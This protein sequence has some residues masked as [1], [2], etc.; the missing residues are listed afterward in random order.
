MSQ[1]VGSILEKGVNWRSQRKEIDRLRKRRKRS[2]QGDE[3]KHIVLKK[4][5]LKNASKAVGE[6]LNESLLK[7]YFQSDLC[8]WNHLPREDVI[9]QIRNEIPSLAQL[10]IMVK[11]YNRVM[12][13]NSELSICGACG[14]LQIGPFK[15]LAIERLSVLRKLDSTPH[16]AENLVNGYHLHRTPSGE[17]ILTFCEKCSESI[18][19]NEIPAY[20][21][22]GG[23]DYGR[24]PDDLATLNDIEQL[25]ISWTIPFG[26]VLKLSQNG[27]LGIKG[28]VISFTNDGP[29]VFASRL[30]NILAVSCIS[31]MFQGTQKQFLM[32][33]HQI[34]HILEIRSAL[35]FRWLHFLKDVNP[36]YADVTID[37]SVDLQSLQEVIRNS[38]HVEDV[39]AAD[40]TACNSLDIEVN[41]LPRL[42]GVFL[43]S[44][45]DRSSISGDSLT[46]LKL[47]SMIL[48]T[49]RSDEPLCEFTQNSELFLSAF[50]YLF[51]LGR[52]LPSQGSI[53]TTLI[54]H[55]LRQ[56][57]GRFATDHRFL[58]LL[59]NQLQRHQAIRAVTSRLKVQDDH[60]LEVESIIN[61]TAFQTQLASI[62]NNIELQKNSWFLAKVHKLLRFVE[63]SSARV[64]YTNSEAKDN[65]SKLYG[66][67]IRYGL[68]SFWLT[69]SPAIHES[70]LALK[71]ILHRNG[72]GATTTDVT[73]GIQLLAKNPVVA[74]ETFHR[75]TD[76][77]LEHL[78][79]FQ[80]NLR[81][82][83]FEKSKGC[84]GSLTAY[85]LVF[86][87]QGRGALHHHGLYWGSV[88]PIIFQLFAH[89]SEIVQ[90]LSR[91][92]D[93]TLR[94]SFPQEY[95]EIHDKL[96]S[97][98][99]RVRPAQ[100]E[101]P[102]PSSTD[103]WY[104][105]YREAGPTMHIHT[106][107][108]TCHK[109]KYGQCRMAFPQ[110]I[111][112]TTRPI[113]LSGSKAHV[114]ASDSID[115][116]SIPSPS[117]YLNPFPRGD[118]RVI[119]WELA[120][121][122]MRDRDVVSHPPVL[123]CAL[124]CNVQASHL[125]AKEDAKSC[126]FYMTGYAC[127]GATKLAATV[128]PLNWARIR[129]AEHR[130]ESQDDIDNPA[131]LF[132]HAFL[133]KLNGAA[134][135]SAQQAASALLQHP[136]YQTSD[137]FSWC[138]ILPAVEQFKFNRISD[139]GDDEPFDDAD[140]DAFV[141][142]GDDIDPLFT[143]HRST[144][145][146]GPCS[147]L[148][149]EKSAS[150]RLLTISQ[151]EHYRLRGEALKHLCFYEWCALIS[152]V[153]RP[154]K[155]EAKSDKRSAGR[156]QNPQYLFSPVH[157]LHG[158]MCQKLRSKICTPR[159]AGPA[160][161]Q[162]PGSRPCGKIT[163]RGWIRKAESFARYMCVLLVPW[164]LDL[165]S[166]DE[167]Q[168][169][170]RQRDWLSLYH[171]RL[172]Q[173][174]SQASQP[175][176]SDVDFNRSLILQNI[177]EVKTISTKH[178]DMLTSWRNRE[179]ARWSAI[180]P[181]NADSSSTS[182]NHSDGS[183]SHD[184]E[185]RHEILQ[186]VAALSD[187]GVSD[188]IDR[189][190]IYLNNQTQA[191]RIFRP[192][193]SLSPTS[194]SSSST[195]Q[196]C[197]FYEDLEEINR[198]LELQSSLPSLLMSSRETKGNG[199]NL[200][201]LD[202]RLGKLNAQQ[203]SILDE[204]KSSSWQVLA[205]ILGGPGTGKSFLSLCISDYLDRELQVAVMQSATTGVAASLLDGGTTIHSALR[206]PV[207]NGRESSIKP[208]VNTRLL[209]I[210]REFAS[211][212]IGVILIDEVSMLTSSML[213][214]V[215]DRLQQILE[216]NRPFGGMSLL[217]V[218]DFFQLE[219]IGSSLWSP[220][221][222][223][224]PDAPAVRGKELFKAF[225]VYELRIQERSTD[226]GHTQRLLEM[227]L[228]RFNPAGWLKVLSDQDRAAF[229]TATI[230]VASNIEKNHI[231][232]IA[233]Q[234][235][236][237][238]ERKP[239]LRWRKKMH[240]NK[241]HIPDDLLERLYESVP[242]LQELFVQGAPVY[243]TK[244][245]C[246]SKKLANGTKG[247]LHSVTLGSVQVFDYDKVSSA[248]PGSIVDIPTPYTVNIRSELDGALVAVKHSYVPKRLQTNRT[249]NLSVCT[250][251]FHL[252]FATTF[253]KAQGM[254][255]SKVIVELNNRRGR[256]KKL[257]QLNWHALYV[258]L[259]RVRCAEDLRII[260]KLTP[261]SFQYLN[262]LKPSADLM[263]WYE[264]CFVS[265]SP[266]L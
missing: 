182:Q 137:I 175:L 115:P 257:G 101:S 116:P 84:L 188:N 37:E 127:K 113:Q 246:P 1:L 256:G 231:N 21:L 248:Q 33:R 211:R 70:P 217:L 232:R 258:A 243:I 234:N 149:V 87:A 174:L 25:F 244:N 151:H 30:P 82:S 7:F 201:D 202:L 2:N 54:I 180:R 68:P 56:N 50:P 171:E 178:K 148:E 172:S 29:T 249:L 218:G 143:Y 262:D 237:L 140:D 95:F 250:H 66:M 210:Q 31:V 57:D 64:P 150:G 225:R 147:L 43:Q 207:D 205:C 247:V 183:G 3:Q 45:Q 40:A 181:Q 263:R 196:S 28:H 17:P 200:Q 76:A 134:E 185:T 221:K 222:L 194:S 260:N 121:P 215:H 46:L 83:T 216:N 203:K 136:S 90:E 32:V 119:K 23:W 161:P 117:T 58:F 103:A 73:T 80:L 159:L 264:S 97:G 162:Y 107:A 20:S 213:T 179:V 106:H 92:L 145:E 86:E 62:Q 39:A 193:E 224:R 96:Q 8:K 197:P 177:I 131:K 124:G 114:I 78:L 169:Q 166:F 26:I 135:I 186:L 129:L 189:T 144:L 104:A 204:I 49:K 75:M 223:Q 108:E 239:I 146:G 38:I 261:T 156:P 245:I 236:A 81:R 128:S 85:F 16:P 77:V 61:D 206:I 6:T 65:L 191:L 141:D 74:A 100:S 13:I 120:R 44:A 132:L 254:T 198:I 255:L 238:L 167:W 184:Q 51:L 142:I 47:K 93:A 110:P 208:L 24:K 111:Q 190:A 253:H 112:P 36:L 98:R 125:G 79:G 240:G 71:L 94:A 123:A 99:I 219:P 35:V 227:R 192:K 27:D 265:Q 102:L 157:P 220:N 199:G 187:G 242:E 53:P 133:N 252:C 229:R 9:H 12:S 164:T 67:I 72:S 158:T 10:S 138:F 109:G 226:A 69:V 126:V 233:L 176:H 195:F 209:E 89:D 105:R 55:L 15:S 91:Y 42:D 5:S 228:G 48:K 59:F 214:Y 63:F 4:Q 152:L 155:K 165:Y 170:G 259:S 41:T 139:N 241:G 11:G 160:P 163:E 88:P 168:Q 251:S 173:H 52:G 19:K 118:N 60:R 153:P 122:T 130:Q 154:K 235:F 22:A 14:I 34:W 18:F 212:R 230:L 266:L